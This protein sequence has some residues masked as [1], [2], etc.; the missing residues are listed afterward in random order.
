MEYYG[1]VDL[2][3][4]CLSEKRFSVVLLKI[5]FSKWNP[6]M[7]FG[8]EFDIKERR[9][10]IMLLG[11]RLS[12]LFRGVVENNTH[13]SGICSIS[14]RIKTKITFEYFSFKNRKKWLNEN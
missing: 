9:F 8:F 4:T 7:I 11:F 13:T 14:T 3:W 10:E 1:K 6:L 5:Y 12:F 2:F